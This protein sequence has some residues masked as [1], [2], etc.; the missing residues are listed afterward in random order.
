MADTTLVDN[1]LVGFIMGLAPV[2]VGLEDLPPEERTSERF[3]Q[4]LDGYLEHIITDMEKDGLAVR[5]NVPLIRGELVK[6]CSTVKLARIKG[7]KH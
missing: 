7:T 3:L 6:A 4:A 5:S 2:I 1:A